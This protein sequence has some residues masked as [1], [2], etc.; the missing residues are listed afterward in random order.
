[1]IDFLR[2]YVVLLAHHLQ[3]ISSE[4][5]ALVILVKPEYFIFSSFLSYLWWTLWTI[6]LHMKRSE[7]PALR[8]VCFVKDFRPSDKFDNPYLIIP[9]VTNDNG[10]HLCEL[11]SGTCFRGL[12]TLLYLHEHCPYI[13][14]YCFCCQNFIIIL[15]KC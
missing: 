2:T 1:M 13:T 10:E 6:L 3:R 9:W 11:V 5:I 15:Q 12:W 4:N 14:Y 7:I 8:L